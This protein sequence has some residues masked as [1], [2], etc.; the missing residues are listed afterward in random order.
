MSPGVPIPSNRYDRAYYDKWYRDPRHRVHTRAA[1]TRTVRYTLSLAEFLLE[2][3]VRS[4]LDVG[5][6]EGQWHALV[7]RER[8]R[9]RY[10]GVDTSAYAVSRFGRSRHLR[11]GSIDGLA[12]LGLRGPFDLVVCAGMLN[13]LPPDTL[14]DSLR[15]L[16]PLVGG[17]AFLEIFTREDAIE[18]N[19][20]GF[21]RRPRGF[22][23][24]VLARTGFVHCGPHAYAGRELA[25]RLVAL[26]RSPSRQRKGTGS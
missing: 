5:A 20:R 10:V 21:H 9:A 3:P 4:V 25:L 2:R 14:E 15:A 24:D 19:T 6:G 23:E 7:R 17:V 26:E 11:L 16:Q 13:Y 22:Y 18:G 12:G 1:R 8:P